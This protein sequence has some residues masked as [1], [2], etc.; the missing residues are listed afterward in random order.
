M[1]KFE[2]TLDSTQSRIDAIM[3]ELKIEARAERVERPSRRAPLETEEEEEEG[4]PDGDEEAGEEEAEE[5]PRR[6]RP[7]SDVDKRL[8]NLRGEVIKELEELDRLELET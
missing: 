3:R 1:K 2:A 8:E 5:R 6:R 7:R 4:E